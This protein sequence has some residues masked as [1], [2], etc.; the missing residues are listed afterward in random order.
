[1]KDWQVA[2]DR[3]EERGTNSTGRNITSAFF[4]ED[5]IEFFQPADLVFRKTV[6]IRISIIDPEFVPVDRIRFVVL[7][8]HSAAGATALVHGT[9][10]NG[11]RGYSALVLSP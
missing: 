11:M 10:A 6:F 5:L 4:E 1:M 8:V 7:L 9:P 3:N 2:I